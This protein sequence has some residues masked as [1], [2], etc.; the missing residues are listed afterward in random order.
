MSIADKLFSFQGRLR[1]RD[2]WLFAILLTVAN[3]VLAAIGMAVVGGSLMPF[4]MGARATAFDYG[5]WLA[6]RL[7]VQ[8]VV[9]LLLLWP[10]LAVSVKRLH[11]RDRSGWWLALIYGLIW[12]QQ[13]LTFMRHSAGVDAFGLANLGFPALVLFLGMVIVGLWL[14]I[15]LGL[16][17]GSAEENR[18]GRSPKAID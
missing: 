1:R 17:D 14:L 9:S 15:E 18:Y 3:M 5:G 6:Q 2:W 12:A 16:L 4:M 7:E 11:D 8:A 10:S 13:G